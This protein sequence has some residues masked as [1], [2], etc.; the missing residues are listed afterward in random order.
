CRKR[1]GPGRDLLVW[2]GK[3]RAGATTDRR[4]WP[5]PFDRLSRTVARSASTSHGRQAAAAYR[6]RR[7]LRHARTRRVR[8]PI[9][10]GRKHYVARVEPRRGAARTTAGDETFGG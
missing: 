6:A 4:R 1:D 8:R 5:V 10:R 3:G 2:P 9:G 7:R